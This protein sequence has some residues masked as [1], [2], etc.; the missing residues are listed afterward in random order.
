MQ[1]VVASR[2]APDKTLNITENK[3]HP[4]SLKGCQ[5][6]YKCDYKLLDKN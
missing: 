3:A 4:H 6:D 5:R 1:I 2:A